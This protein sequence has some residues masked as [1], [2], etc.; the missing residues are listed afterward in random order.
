[1]VPHVIPALS[2]NDSEQQGHKPCGVCDVPHRGASYILYIW[3]LCVRG[4][5]L[6]TGTVQAWLLYK[7]GILQ[8]SIYAM[9]FY[10]Q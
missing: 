4:L 3:N 1:M 9:A 8:A 7:E 5:A 10:S 2:V 6:A